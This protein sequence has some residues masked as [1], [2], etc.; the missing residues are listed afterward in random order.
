MAEPLWKPSADGIAAAEITRFTAFAKRAWNVQAE[1]YPALHRWSVEHPEQ[2]WDA[3]WGFAEII[4]DRKGDV[5]LEDA[6]RMPGARWFPE[7]W[8]NYAENLLR[9][10]DDG[11]AIEFRG[12]DQ[13]RRS[14]SYAELYDAVAVLAMALADAGVGRGDRV[15]GYLPNLPEAIISMLATTSL[16]AV[17]SSCSPDF[18]VRGVVD[19]FGQ[20]APK[21]LFTADGYFYNGKKHDS[22]ARVAEIIKELP[23]VERV[24][25]VPYTEVSPDIS[26]V[27]RAVDLG[28]FTAAYRP[29]DIAFARLP[30]D[31][32]LFIM[33]SSGTTGAPKCMVHGAG[34]TLIQHVKEHQLQSD[35]R[36]D[37]RVMFFTTCGWMMWNWLASVLAS[38]ATLLLYEGAPFYPDGNA[39]FDFADETGMTHFGTSAKF[40]DALKKSGLKP[41]E[42]HSLE[43]LRAMLSTGSPLAPES[44]DFVYQHIKS[45]I[46]L[47]SI[48]GGT[49]IISCFA[50]GNPALPVYRGEIQCIGLGMDVA[51]F[52]DDG[53]A[54]MGAKGELV[55]RT[56]FPSMPVGFWNDPDGSKYQAAY[57]EKF[58][59]VWCHG[60][61][62]ALTS[63]G[64]MI[65]YGR[66]DAILNPGGVRIGTAE[67]Y[68]QVEQ[69]DEVVESLVIGQEWD[70]DVRVVLFV[71]LR[72]GLIVDD[73]M[74]DRIKEQIRHN[75]T[76]R[77][78]P[79][80]IVQVPDIPR[81]KN[82]KIVEI[83]VRNVVHGKA[84]KNKDALANPEALEY[85]R[86]IALLRV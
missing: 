55:C 27:P 1:D 39:L 72:D 64:G 26:A 68:R 45:D 84:V 63:N 85:Y 70:D 49:D 9:R 12:E 42:N 18:G 81:T 28:D 3:M 61:Y 10:R 78:V 74:R 71:V 58:P 67:I 2:F 43:T 83:A 73:P 50:L 59:D 56:P 30:F 48:T 80:K 36:R 40:I 31:H 33:Y 32:P 34:G 66:S 11:I 15:A 62:V 77:H 41:A 47:S 23:D 52:D 46:C 38:G 8:L 54:V 29:G 7:A 60:D 14:L 51:A 57:F 69:F 25:V 20:I 17:W 79:A 65:V 53:N 44:F 37:D 16:G 19:R 22:L 5:I 4:A 6:D 35:I 86:D 13:V 82:G 21:V 75:T 76:P 24:I